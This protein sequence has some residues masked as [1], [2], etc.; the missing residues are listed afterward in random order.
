VI[1]HHSLAPNFSDLWNYTEPD[2]ANEKLSE[3][4]LAAQFTS[5]PASRGR[6]ANQVHLYFLSQYLNLPQMYRDIAGGREYQRLRT[7]YYAYDVY[8]RVNDSRFWKSFKTK[9]AVNNPAAGSGYELGDL[10]IMYL[11]NDP[12]DTRF[13]DAASL[14]NVVDP[15]TGKAIPSVFVRYYTDGTEVLSGY[16]NRFAPLSKYIDG[17][18]EGVSDAMGY[19]D[20]ILARVGET[21]LIAAEALIKQEKYSEALNYINPI[22]RRAAY[23]AGEDRT[24][25]CDGGAAYANNST[26]Q[27]SFGAHNSYYPENSYYE[28]NN[29]PVTTAATDIEV[30]DIQQLPAEDER[31]IAKLN[32]T[33]DYD[34]MMCFL[35]NERSRELMGEFHRWEDLSRTLTLVARARAYNTEA[36]PNIKDYHNLRPIPQTFLDAIQTQG[37]ALT[38]A[39]KTAMQNP[40]Y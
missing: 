25:Y 24:A 32:Y 10:S 5:A 11:I 35:L 26:G 28:S 33:G 1:A 15:K 27:A 9:Y 34:R 6:Y 20:G 39:E 7:T 16:L 17:S 8:D 22:R 21:Y 4:I 38:P 29:I 18:R 31:I 2:G 40:G 30:T 37:R 12:G 19:R 36:S 13:P 14:R 3:I 23:K